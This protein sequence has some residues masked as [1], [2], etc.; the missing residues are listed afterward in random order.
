MNELDEGDVKT[1]RAMTMGQWLK[2]GPRLH[3]T[4]AAVQNRVGPRPS[5]G[6]ERREG[7]ERSSPLGPRWNETGRAIRSVAGRPTPPKKA[8]LPSH[9]V[10]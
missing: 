3:G 10:L 2:R 4:S 9:R 6:M 7:D 8:R 5:S 1:L